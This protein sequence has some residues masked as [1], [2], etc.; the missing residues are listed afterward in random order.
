MLI[1][2]IEHN[3]PE[4]VREILEQMGLTRPAPA[5][6]PGLVGEPIS[7]VPLPTRRALAVLASPADA[8]IVAQLVRTIDAE[9]ASGDQHVE[10]VP[11]RLADAQAVA[12]TLQA[13]LRTDD[14]QSPAGPAAALA[15]HVRRL[16]LDQRQWEN[17]ELEIDLTLPIRI[18][19]DQQT[20]SVLIGSTRPNV[21]ALAEV[22]RT[23]DTLPVGDAVVVRIFPLQ[24]AAA[25][26]VRTVIE[27]LFRQGEALRRLPGTRRQ[28]LPT[29]TTGQA[30]AG[31]IA[32]T[33]DE[34]TNAL[35]VAGREEAVAFVE[36]LIEQLDSDETSSWVEPRLIRL[37]YA[38]PVRLA[39]TL[40]AVLVRGVAQSPEALGMQQQIARLRIALKGGGDAARAEADLF[41]PMSRLVIVPEEDLRALIVV[42]SQGN[43]AV[44]AELVRMLDVEAAAAD[45]N[46]R[47]FPLRH[48]AADRVARVVREV[49]REREQVGAARPEDRLIVSADARTNALVVSTSPR[50]MEILEGLIGT[51]DA[52][53]ADMSVGVHVLPVPGVDVRR[54]AP[55]IERLMRERQEA[56]RRAGVPDSPSDAFSVVAE[57]AT[58]TLIIAASEE[59]LQVVRELIGSLGAGDIRGGGDAVSELVYVEK[60]QAVELAQAIAELYVQRENERRGE[61]A[62]TVIPN[63]RL[64][65]LIVTGTA[66]DVQNVRELVGQLSRAEVRT[67]QDIRRIELRSANALEVVNLLQQVLAGRTL[68]GRAGAG[69]ATRLRFYRERLK[70]EV[71]DQL[72]A[73]TEAEIDGALRDQ[74]RLTP[75][76]RTN[77][78]VIAAPPEIMGLIVEIIDDLDTTTAG[79]RKIEMFRLENADAF[80][81]AEV[82]R[83]LFN[84][85]QQGNRFVLI[86]TPVVAEPG[87]G[88]EEPPLGRS[89]GGTTLTP[90]PDS[91]QELSMTIDPRTNTLLVSGTP[92]LLDLVRSVVTELDLIK[93]TEREQL[94]VH[95]RNAKAQEV[96]ETLQSYFRDE[97]NRIRQTL[98]PE[99]IG[100]LAR[101]LEQEVTLVGDEKSNKIVVSASPRYIGTIRGIIEELDAAPPQVVIEVLLAEVTIDSA[102]TWGLE[103]QVGPFGGEDYIVGSMPAGAALA[104]ALGVPNLSVS[105]TD[106]SLLIRALEE[107]GRLEVLSRPHVIVNNNEIGFIQVVENISVIDSVDRFESGAVSANVVREDVGIILEVIPTISADG[108]VRMEIGPEISALSQRSIP[109]SA[110]FEAPIITR[111]QVNTVITVLDGQ[112][113]VLGGLLQTSDEERFTKVPFLGD[114][115]LAGR[116]FQTDRINKIKTEL[117]VILTPTV[118]R[119]GDGEGVQR[120]RDI[121]DRHID[122]MTARERIR[123]MLEEAVEAE[124]SYD[125]DEPAELLRPL[126]PADA[127]DTQIEADAPTP[128]RGEGDSR[129]APMDVI[130]ERGRQSGDAWWRRSE[131][132][133]RR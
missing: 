102:N 73:F 57:P 112:T 118:I 67:A 92:D 38:D 12:Q 6:R 97:A 13:L 49:F 107:Q 129:D 108:F 124:P 70:T 36:V 2:D 24:N 33:V 30:L 87:E 116:L 7:I 90:V 61:R 60:G 10:L 106:F 128:G 75:D 103:F 35:V 105:S 37:E 81:M 78:V 89:F 79:N 115:P 82:L 84:L 25:G 85:Q 71:R 16:S 72:G 11:M 41:T 27:D 100:S 19:A 133:D 21:K 120:M 20:N 126:P 8:E 5:D 119:G 1:I 3:S 17:G 45:N 130:P 86:P 110:D 4:R 127:A 65:V 52:E 18:L 63:D 14:Q 43:A 28:G 51:L 53:E 132:D 95:L 131:S 69:Q 26:R 55:M 96:E 80:A 117:L 62:V 44:V 93:A 122:A 29:T 68:S 121:S 42:G 22:A 47:V 46:V 101:L 125:P 56:S 123:A 104:T 15:E 58:G 113:V 111:R 76:L 66:Q 91:R 99:Q 23:L 109:I 59:N 74:V 9:P 94:V 98:G 88:E 50:S 64:N 34:R 114:I 40:E 39:Q 32:A 31:E 83:D 77:S 54:L 48:A